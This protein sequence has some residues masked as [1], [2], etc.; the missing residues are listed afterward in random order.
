M[1]QEGFQIRTPE[2]FTTALDATKTAQGGSDSL[3]K[4]LKMA[5]GALQIAE[6]SLQRGPGRPYVENTLQGEVGG[7]GQVHGPGRQVHAQL[8]PAPAGRPAQL[9]APRCDFKRAPAGSTAAQDGA[10]GRPAQPMRPQV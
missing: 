2:S 10:N 8:A 6:E 4:G 9:S 3:P 1:A 7:Q 5:P